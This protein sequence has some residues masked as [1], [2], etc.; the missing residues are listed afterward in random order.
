[1]GR[2]WVVGC[3]GNCGLKD[4]LTVMSL[5]GSFACRRHQHH[6][7]N[8]EHILSLAFEFNAATTTL[9]QFVFIV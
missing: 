1:V 3:D 9:R 6:K 4:T 2:A 5:Q 7:W 8:G